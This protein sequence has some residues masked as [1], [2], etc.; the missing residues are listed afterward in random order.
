[1]AVTYRLTEHAQGLGPA[2]DALRMWAGAPVNE[3]G[4]LLPHTE[5]DEPGHGVSTDCDASA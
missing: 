4:Q 5:A 1:M 2:M 3:E